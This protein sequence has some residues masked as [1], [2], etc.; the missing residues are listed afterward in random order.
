MGSVNAR[1]S[2]LRLFGEL[3]RINRENVAQQAINDRCPPAIPVKSLQ[4]SICHI[5]VFSFTPAIDN[6]HFKGFSMNMLYFF[7]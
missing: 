2:E 4:G 6:F 7:R 3:I 5:Q 1:L